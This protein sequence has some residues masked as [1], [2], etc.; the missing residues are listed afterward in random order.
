MS[1]QLIHRKTM[2]ITTINR[3]LKPKLSPQEYQSIVEEIRSAQGDQQMKQ[4]YE[5][6]KT[7]TKSRASTYGMTSEASSSSSSSQQ[8]LSR[9][10]TFKHK[11]EMIK[12][13][14]SSQ[15]LDLV[16]ENQ[17][18]EEESDELR[19]MLN[20]YV[21]T[22][23]EANIEN[24][25][26]IRKTFDQSYY[27]IISLRDVPPE[28][29][30]EYTRKHLLRSLGRV[31][32]SRLQPSIPMQLD[33]S[34]RKHEKRKE[35]EELK[36]EFPPNVYHKSKKK[37]TAHFREN[38]AEK[39]PERA[40]DVNIPRKKSSYEQ[41]IKDIEN[42]R[43]SIRQPRMNVDVPSV[44]IMQEHAYIEPKG[45]PY[46]IRNISDTTMLPASELKHNVHGKYKQPQ[47]SQEVSNFPIHLPVQMTPTVQE[48]SR[49][50]KP[51][52]SKG[53]TGYTPETN[54]SRA[55]EQLDTPIGRIYT[56][57][58][59]VIPYRHN[60][61]NTLSSRNKNLILEMSQIPAET[62]QTN[63][64][65]V[66]E[67][68]KEPQQTPN[69]VFHQPTQPEHYT[70]I[71]PEPVIRQ[72]PI[73]IGV[74]DQQSFE[75]IYPD[76]VRIPSEA[77]Y[78]PPRRPPISHFVRTFGTRNYIPPRASRASQPLPLP[79]EELI[80]PE[81]HAPIDTPIDAPVPQHQ[82]VQEKKISPELAKE[83]IS[84]YPKLKKTIENVMMYDYLK[85]GDVKKEDIDFIKALTLTIGQP[86]SFTQPMA[87]KISK[88]ITVS[89][90]KPTTKIGWQDFYPDTHA[91]FIKF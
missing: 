61:P 40:K 73:H 34:R 88:P 5:R 72:K 29:Q 45:I 52:R 26:A 16:E 25:R 14:Y 41:P 74:P 11:K 27:F 35:H 38:P 91:S 54:L 48:P 43:W 23:T 18:S 79:E 49:S 19:E 86:I 36:E 65:S 55:R 66:R 28:Q 84:R 89:K 2:Y 3:W 24:I 7:L 70:P 4:I 47:P 10:L 85:Q 39:I 56:S 37:K 90:K 82:V 6:Y 87:G 57:T 76:P 51:T 67:K 69:I 13:S 83:L 53:K 12:E 31:Y 32:E 22:L 64:L 1:D 8:E 21:D 9:P 42:I 77:G 75:R 80:Q 17:L 62:S 63:K 58:A 50:T 44:G 15:I 33:P 68:M 46:R 71:Y 59:D 30:V 60:L 20:N 78:I 81:H